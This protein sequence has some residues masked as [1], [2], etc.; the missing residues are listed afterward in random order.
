VGAWG[1]RSKRGTN[2][3]RCLFPRRGHGGRLGASFETLALKRNAHE[4][5]GCEIGIVIYTC[6]FVVKINGYFPYTRYG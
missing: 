4:V 2:T 1:L 6:L 5:D 3:D